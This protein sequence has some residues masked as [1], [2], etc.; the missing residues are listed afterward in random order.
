MQPGAY[1]LELYRGDNDAWTFHLW[2][3]DARTTPVDLTGT[4]AAAEIRDKP[5]GAR[6]V[7]LDVTIT[8]PAAGEILVAVGAEQWALTMPTRGVWTCSSPTPAVGCPPWWP[9]PRT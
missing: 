4:T 5:A 2:A 9:A 8:D 1:D 3:D 7:P 6:V